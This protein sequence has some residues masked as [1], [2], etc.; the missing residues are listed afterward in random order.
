MHFYGFSKSEAVNGRW[1]F[2]H[3]KLSRDNPDAVLEITR[4]TRMSSVSYTPRDEFE[5]LKNEVSELKLFIATEVK[6]M[7]DQVGELW[8]VVSA[9]RSAKESGSNLA[10]ND[11]EDFTHFPGLNLGTRPENQFPYGQ[12]TFNDTEL[13]QSMPKRK[14]IKIAPSVC[15]GGTNASSDNVSDMNILF[16][17]FPLPICDYEENFTDSTSQPF[18]K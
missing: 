15:S 2:S 10:F 8:K 4:K 7:K 3:P 11:N 6:Q 16:D 1:T 12:N 13:M 5:K 9:F 18:A 17:G 14:K